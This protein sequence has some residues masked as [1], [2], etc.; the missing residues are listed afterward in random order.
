M[1]ARVLILAYTLYFVTPPRA[2]PVQVNVTLQP[3][4]ACSVFM[5]TLVKWNVVGVVP[6]VYLS[7]PHA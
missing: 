2:I 6:L 3:L 7:V 5:I 1:Y 4:P